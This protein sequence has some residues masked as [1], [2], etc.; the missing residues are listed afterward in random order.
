MTLIGKIWAAIVETIQTHRA[1]KWLAEPVR[2]IAN[3]VVGLTVVIGGLLVAATQF[4]HLVPAK[5][6][7][8]FTAFLAVSTVVIATAAKI[9]GEIARSK[10][11]APATVAQ[12]EAGVTAAVQAVANADSSPVAT[13]EIP[14]AQIPGGYVS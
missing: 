7:D 5:Y 14:V 10:V 9:A 3:Y 11:F 4:T 2:R 8:D 13:E 6:Q 1:P 12:I